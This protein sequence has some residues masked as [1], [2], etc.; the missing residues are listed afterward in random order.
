[1]YL[2]TP[3]G[4]SWTPDK[5]VPCI[6]C[7]CNPYY[8]IIST[9]SSIFMHLLC[10]IVERVPTL[11]LNE[12]EREELAKLIILD[13]AWLSLVMKA[14]VELH[15]SN[16]SDDRK[17]ARRLNKEGVASKELLMYIWNEFLPK[18]DDKDR[19]FHH[20]CTTLKAY[21]LIY[22]LKESSIPNLEDKNEEISASLSVSSIC[23]SSEKQTV[24]L[25]LIPCMLP[26]DTE[27]KDDHLDWITFHFDFEKFL[28]KVLY[29][30]FI[31][32]LIAD[33]QRANVNRRTSPQ[34]SKS[35][36]RFNNIRGCNWKIELLSDVHRLK[37][38]VL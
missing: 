24:N 9:N 26:E 11:Y 27:G 33:F 31:C 22:P 28:P 5:T 12:K 6:T 3:S 20:L 36:C 25:F 17:L 35:W 10:P 4:S 38:S 32:Q 18:T 19:S 29:H 7:I 14:V 8:I 1:M 37:I 23:E 30:R 21:C 16:F 34:Y 13:P 2:D 15:P